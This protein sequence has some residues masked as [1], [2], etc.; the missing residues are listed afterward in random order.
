MRR[1]GRIDRKYE[2][3]IGRKTGRD[4]TSCP[5][6]AKPRSTIVKDMEPKTTTTQNPAPTRHVVAVEG[7]TKRYGQ[8]TA[9]GDLS[10]AVPA[11]E[12][13]G[14]LGPNGA[15]KTTAMK[16]MVGLVRPSAG[17]ASLLGTPTTDTGFSHILRR[18]GV[19]IEAPALYERLSARTNLELQ[20]AALGVNGDAARLGELLDLV[21]LTD[22]ADDKAGGYSLG[23]K[24]RLGI[25]LAM[26]GRPELVILDEPAN[27]LDPA[28]IVEIRRLLRRLPEM[29]TTVLVSSHQLSEVQQ[30][31]DRLVVLAQGRLVTAGTTDEILRDHSTTDFTVRVSPAD[32]SVAADAL[33]EAR[34]AV[35]AA[36]IDTLT[37]SLPDGWSGRDLN[38]TLVHRDVFATELVPHTVTLE[39]AF[40]AMTQN[41]NTSE[42]TTGSATDL[43]LQGA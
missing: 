39:E 33:R 7:L 27:G 3:R 24:Q 31:C 18:V 15:G 34:L 32:V 5:M 37:V 29:G 4:L 13:V 20:A 22:R 2:V 11:G 14:L 9:V 6:A 8:H 26:V 28:G 1:R 38:R 42:P 21:D 19:L 23:M 17:G 25:A 30:A 41:P 16:M 36:G 10:F 12:V 43:V 40:L 35:V